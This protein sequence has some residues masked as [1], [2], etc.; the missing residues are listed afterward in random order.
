M[1]LAFC[2]FKYFPFGG[3]QRDMVKITRECLQRGHQVKIFTLRWD[4][5]NV[6][7]LELPGVELDI[8]PISGLNR[9]T[10][11]NHF[12]D[13]VQKAVSLDNFDLVVGFNK[14][15][16][17]DV[18]YG[19]DSCYYAKALQQRS[20][21]YRLLPRF[22]N[23][24]RAEA[25]VFGKHSSTQILM[26]SDIEQPSYRH[27]YQTPVER[28]HPLPPGIEKDRIAPD[29][30]TELRQ[31]LR[32]EFNLHEDT[33]V[34]LCVGSGF[35]KKGL[36]RSLTAVAALPAELRDRVHLFVIGRDKSEAFERLAMRLG[37]S[38]QVTFFSRG[39]E[40]VPRFLFASDALLHP[41]YDETAGMV[42]IES[43]LA[44]LPA[45]VTRNC[46]YAKYLAEHDAG[47]VL[48]KPFSQL[49]LNQ[50]VIDVLTSPR[51]SDWRRNGLAAREQTS[52]FR[53]VPATVDYLERFARGSK[54][55]LVFVLFKYFPYGGL[56]RDF[57]RVAMCAQSMGYEILVYC[58]EWQ[59]VIPKGFQVIEVDAP[60]VSNHVRHANFVKF[61]REDVRWRQ[62]AAVIGFN[63]VPGL[64]LYYAADSC[65]EHKAQ[66][67]RASLYR[68]TERYKVMSGF[69]QS[70]FGQQSQT[71]I[72]L[73]A[74]SQKAQYQQYY[75]T[76]TERLSLLGPGVNSDRC[77]P[78]NWPELRAAIRQEFSV[79]NDEFLV[80]LI[81]S[82]FITKGLDR[83]LQMLNAFP[84][85][86]AARVRLLVIGQDNPRAFL[87][88]ARSLGIADRLRIEKGRDDIPAILQGADLMVHP[89]YM[90][91][92]GMVLIESV[93]AG[94]PVIA[95]SACGFAHYI[96]EADAGIVLSEP[97]EQQA[98]NDAAAAALLNATQRAAWSDNGVDYGRRHPE[99]YNMPEQAM[100]IIVDNIERRTAAREA[101][102][103]AEESSC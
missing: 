64:D 2:I 77:R 13:H 60:G 33:L 74:E 88:Q 82:G 67:M 99:L 3:I 30:V 36:D 44:G 15:P 24:Y 7:S 76:D 93:I 40:D 47:I 51:R 28:F 22:R 68:R 31:Q 54:P 80:V 9:H 100:G 37:I 27:H 43:M 18:Y 61:Y 38:A 72:M 52:L 8:A 42:I 79:Q 10:Q 78:D 69:E 12:A 48:D 53:L 70:I 94:L 39:R 46:G 14:M 81:G 29:N 59:S 16:G 49:G 41:A 34:L 62:P 35:I 63:R 58:I 75:H 5:P 101:Q 45:I 26:L 96:E 57:M 32:E 87:R 98:L 89:A 25:A 65:F 90:E 20:S 102:W 71:H 85:S 1:R 55:L 83:V 11:Y 91:S 23:L 86:L 17:L 66:R 21:W 84:D 56:Q 92:G 6:E 103:A 95:S 73:I 50:A 97:F 4:A 19:G